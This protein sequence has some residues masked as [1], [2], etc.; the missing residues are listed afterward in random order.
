MARDETGATPSTTACPAVRG[1][2]APSARSHIEFRLT[3]A[4]GCVV[5]IRHGDER[6]GAEHIRRRNEEVGGHPIDDLA[7]QRMD[8]ALDRPGHRIDDQFFAFAA[9]AAGGSTQCVF[10]DFRPYDGAARKGVI[11]SYL[12]PGHHDAQGCD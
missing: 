11:T 12:K 2:P 6:F 5:P 1:D 4:E 10:V 8:D 3:D 7:R 9:S